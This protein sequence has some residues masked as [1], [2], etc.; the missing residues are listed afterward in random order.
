MDIKE[1][2]F[3]NQS[4]LNKVATTYLAILLEQKQHLMQD[5]LSVPTEL[6]E[7][8]AKWQKIASTSEE[9]NKEKVSLMLTPEEW[10]V[11][12]N[13]PALK[14]KK[15]AKTM[16]LHDKLRQIMTVEDGWRKIYGEDKSFDKWLEKYVTVDSLSVMSGEE[17]ITDDEL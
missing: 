7:S 15:S 6:E 17:E 10:E 9:Q 8:I 2:V 3:R 14:V 11:I 1:I 13:L 12:S 4:V 16:S 5:N